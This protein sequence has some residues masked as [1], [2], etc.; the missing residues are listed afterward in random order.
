MAKRKLSQHQSR[1]IKKKQ[2]ASNA[3]A[4]SPL[5]AIDDQTLGAE[6]EGRVIA[7]YGTQVDIEYGNNESIRCFLRANLDPVI[8]GDRIVWQRGEDLGVVVSRHPRSSLLSRPDTYGKLKPVAANVDQ[9]IVTI[10]PQPEFFTNLI[11]RYLVVAELNHIKPLILINKA[12]LIDDENAEKFEDLKESYSGIGYQVL[13]F[14]AKTEIGVNAL[15]SQLRDKTSILVGQSGVGKSSILKLLMPEEEIQVGQLSD[16]KNKGRHT[17]THSQLFH[18]SGGGECIDSPG[19]RE[20]GLWNLEAPDVIKGFVELNA[21]TDQCKFRD[22][23]HNHEPG[24]AI[25]N[26]RKEKAISETRFISYQR[27][28]ASLDDVQIKTPHK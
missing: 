4:A 8:T 20:F 2:D 7:H 14:S 23:S 26:A 25:Q 22:C 18:F 9:I 15:I 13:L 6:Q 21:L 19:I 10:A 17:T 3:K 11:D 5:D 28:V 16:A 27:I 24:C 12:D 1:R